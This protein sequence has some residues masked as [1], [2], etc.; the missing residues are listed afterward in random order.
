MGHQITNTC[1]S[2]PRK[3]ATSPAADR[4]PVRVRAHRSYRENVSPVLS[5]HR[6]KMNV[7]SQLEPGFLVYKSCAKKCPLTLYKSHKNQL[8]LC[9]V[10][11]GEFSEDPSPSA[12]IMLYT[13]AVSLTLII[14]AVS[15]SEASLSSGKLFIP[16][17]TTTR[18]YLWSE[19]TVYFNDQLCH[20]SHC[21]RLFLLIKLNK[22]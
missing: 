16:L 15:P 21:H 7:W 5:S 14:D 13:R 9:L 4:S 2:S 17:T 12:P 22:G 18:G 8:F 6:C 20:P 10:Y 1:V 19:V 11:L 3:Q